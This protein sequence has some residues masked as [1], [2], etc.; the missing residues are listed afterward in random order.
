MTAASKDVVL[1]GMRTTGKLHIGHYYGALKTWIEL[2][3][4]YR[5]YYMIA[6]WH[7]LTSDYADTSNIESNIWDMVIDWFACGLD[8]KR[9][10][11]FR[12]SWVPEHAELHLYLSMITPLSWLERNPTYK[13]QID[14]I[15]NKD[16]STYGFLGYPVLQAAD[17]LMYKATRVPVGEDQLPHLELTREITRRFNHLYGNVLLEPQALLSKSP[18]ILGT[19][20]RKMSKSYNNAVLLSDT[21]EQVDAKIKTMFTDPKKIR[22]NDPGNPYGC[23]VFNTHKVYT[24]EVAKI[25]EDCKTGDLGCVDCKKRLMETLNAGLAPIREARAQWAG[26][27]NEVKEIV[28]AGSEQA[29]IVAQSTLKEV[30]EALHF[31]LKPG[32]PV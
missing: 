31:Q 11:I 14:A 7:A 24:P 22:K 8:P 21:K 6:D 17:I 20:G 30:R 27:L 28:R 4:K 25:E 16:L 1:S 9:C 3:E 23:V 10:V 19:D 12:Q 5:C 18:K 29:R 26:R 32:A 13:E 15:Q 2:Q